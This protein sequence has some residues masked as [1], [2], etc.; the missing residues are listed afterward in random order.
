MNR[1]IN[2]VRRRHRRTAV[3]A[4]VIAGLLAACGG[5][6]SSSSS[7]GDNSGSAS[8]DGGSGATDRDVMILRDMDLSTLDLHRMWCD[9]CMIVLSGVYE[10]LVNVDPADPSK[11]VPGLATEWSANE[12][13]TEFTFRLNPAATFADG[14]AVTSA[15]V[16]WSY[17]RSA[18]MK[19]GGSFMLTGLVRVD[20]PDPQTA[21]VVFDKPNAPFLKIAGAAL[22]LSVA[23]SALLTE[24]AGA[25]TGP[26]SDTD[27]ADT[28]FSQGKSAGSG[29]YVVESFTSED[30][31]VLVRNENYW[32]NA[33]PFASITIKEVTD[34]ASQLLQMQSG[35]ADIAMNISFDSLAEVDTIDGVTATALDSYNFIHLNLNQHAPGGEPFADVRVRQAIRHAIDYEALIEATLAGNG[36]VQATAIPNGFPGTE[37]LPL[38]TYDVDKAK[39]LLAEAGYADGFALEAEYFQANIYGVEFDVMWQRIQQDL[40]AV[41]IDLTLKPVDGPQWVDTMTT[42]GHAFTTTFFAPD[43]IDASEYIQ[44]FGPVTGSPRGFGVP[45]P[46][47]ELAIDAEADALLTEGLS[48]VEPARWATWAKIGQIMVDDAEVLPVVNPKT[49]FVTVDD[50][51]IST[52]SPCCVLDLARL[53][54]A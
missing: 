51:P 15:D 54:P 26:G 48:Q 16:K 25:L 37:D 8:T 45:S 30:R 32:G 42:E 13:N 43:F 36:R 20:T 49:L 44:Y 21:V 52:L 22:A 3:A 38:P 19:A 29:P 9:T 10:R 4:L 40:D 18:N 53:A 35:D 24:Q 23:N 17:E 28:W 27:P 14:T 7:S 33:A 2:S 11:L 5:D 46:G 6:S 12:D 31:I 50:I 41:G 1:R 39:E 47:A 34:S